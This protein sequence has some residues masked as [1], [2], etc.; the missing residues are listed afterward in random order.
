[1]A[2][3]HTPKRPELIVGESLLPAVIP[4]LQELGV[5]EEI[6]SF[7]TF[8]PGATIVMDEVTKASFDFTLARTSNA[9]AYNVPRAQFDEAI[10]NAAVRAGAKLIE[11][12]ADIETFKTSQ[13]VKLNATSLEALNGYFKDE[14][15]FIIDASGRQ[16][17]I[18]KK[19]NLPSQEGKRK[20]VALFA[21][22]KNVDLISQGNIHVDRLKQGWAW[23]IPLPGRV[24]LGVVI[25]PDHLKT[26]GHSRE[27]Q[28][29][30]FIRQESTLKE[31]VKNSERLTSVM[32]YTNYQWKSEQLYGPGW[33]LVGD[34]A[35]F[36]DPVFSTGLFLAMNSAFRFAEAFEKNTE[37]ALGKY[38]SEWQKELV[39]WQTII[40][41]WY[42]G[43]L[44]ALFKMGQVQ[45]HTVFGKLINRH[46]TKHVTRIFTGEINHGNYSHKLLNFMT[47]Y[48][49]RGPEQE[50][51]RIQ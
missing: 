31:L 2:L 37:D 15:D 20:D 47:R 9:Y 4:M 22:L 39:T 36:I 24:S 23:R 41:T 48:G 33:A 29:D 26:L 14:I 44:L 43:K 50:Q 25:N 12:K 45:R 3:F 11:H 28:Y 17:L 10:L 6:K 21:H 40:D 8:K 18:P 51:L 27:E 32:S 34:T 19:L 38:Q 7:S 46:M 5:E 1:V 16:R 13:K 49:I 35:G 30:N 42:D